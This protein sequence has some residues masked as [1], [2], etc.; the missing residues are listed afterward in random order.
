[1]GGNTWI[2][3]LYNEVLNWEIVEEENELGEKVK[4]EG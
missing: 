3:T 4:K 1:M 2:D